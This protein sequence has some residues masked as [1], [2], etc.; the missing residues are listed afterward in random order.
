MMRCC[1]LGGQVGNVGTVPGRFNVCMHDLEHSVTGFYQY[2]I[3]RTE[4]SMYG[5]TERGRMSSDGPLSPSCALIVGMFHELR[6]APLWM[7]MGSSAV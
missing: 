1:L 3:G 4:R 5:H 7:E 2:T 6:P